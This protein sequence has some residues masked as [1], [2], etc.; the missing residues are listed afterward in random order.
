MR[1]SN[2]AYNIP[3][4]PLTQSERARD[5]RLYSSPIYKFTHKLR[6]LNKTLFTIGA[7]TLIFSTVLYAVVLSFESKLRSQYTEINNLF[8][9][10][11]ELEYNYSISKSQQ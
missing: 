5:F 7:L 2:N 11:Q 4:S 9:E 1:R 3:H 6:Q 10:H 8:H